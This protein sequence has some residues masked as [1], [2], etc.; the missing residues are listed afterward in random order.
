MEDG[1]GFLMIGGYASFGE[2]DWKGTAVE[3]LLPVD[4]SVRG[5][6]PGGLYGI[7]MVPTE[8]GL[9]LYSHV[10]RLGGGDAKAEQD[11]WDALPGLDGVN[12][13]AQPKQLGPTRS[14]AW[15]NR[16]KRTPRRCSRTRCW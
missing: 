3:P 11:A 5:Q 6:V 9:R 1:A 7:K 16:R 14:G 4:L 10:L 13:I 12:R 2:G 8:I 15:P